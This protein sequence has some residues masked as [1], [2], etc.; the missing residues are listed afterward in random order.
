MIAETVTEETSVETTSTIPTLTNG[1][2]M[3]SA[4]TNGD[5]EVKTTHVKVELPQ[6]AGEPP[7]PESTEEMLAKAREMVAEARKL[8]GESIA[9]K[10]KAEDIVKD[11]EEEE[12]TGETEEGGDAPQTKKAKVLVDQLRKERVKTRAWMGL[13]ATLAIG[14]ILPY[15]L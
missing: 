8:E 11:G 2:F 4:S 12:D 13:S 10:R 6:A 14:A 7:S 15:V 3:Q 9:P 5:A 1:E